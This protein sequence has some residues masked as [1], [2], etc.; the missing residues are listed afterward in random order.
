[1]GRA[2]SSLVDGDPRFGPPSPALQLPRCLGECGLPLQG[3][4]VLPRTS[5]LSVSTRNV[6]IPRTGPPP[7]IFR[8]PEDACL[9]Y[10]WHPMTLKTVSPYQQPTWL[11]LGWKWPWP[12]SMSTHAPRLLVAPQ[13]PRSP[14]T[15]TSPDTQGF[16][17]WGLRQR[18][19]SPCFFSFP[20][21]KGVS[22]AVPGL[23]AH[24]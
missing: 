11:S 17:C 24:S 9:L 7:T 21:L 19:N 23:P 8:P 22:M 6:G 1:M 3:G 15:A 18:T 4:W 12:A 16:L 10:Q 14:P 5:S 20:S 2:G 13:T